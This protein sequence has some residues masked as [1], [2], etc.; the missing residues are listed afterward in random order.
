MSKYR[1]GVG[2][3]PAEDPRE[4]GDSQVRHGLTR[5]APKPAGLG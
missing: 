4:A 2:L 5:R 3:L 1:L